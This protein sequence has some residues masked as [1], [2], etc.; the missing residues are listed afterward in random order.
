VLLA[1]AGLL[2]IVFGLIEG[3][4]YDWGT[5]WGPVSIP[6]IIAAGI[7]LLL[8][9][10]VSQARQQGREPLL[11]FRLFAD[12]NF[13]LMSAVM[14]AMGFAM[15]GLFLPLTIYYQSVLGL[16]AVDAGL[17]IAPQPLAMMVASGLAASLIPRVGGKRLLVPGLILFAAGMAAINWVAGADSGRWS[18]LPGLVVSGVGLG[19]IWTPVF[20]LATGTLEP[21]LAGVASGV[22]STIQEL[23]GVLASAMIGALLQNRL[24]LALHARAVDAA[25][26][27]PATER[28]RFVASFSN[29]AKHGFQVGRGESGT[30]M[31]L[32]PG[33]PPGVEEQ[34]ASA[35]HSVFTHAFVDAMRPS[36]ALP[37]AVIGLAALASLAAR[38]V[39][40]AAATQQR[41]EVPA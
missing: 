25:A 18:F 16:S 26:A 3:Q 12:R 41:E 34:L 39:R 17:T 4:R 20:S 14:A 7:V 21:R 15:L 40:A 5:V 28:A 2:G 6:E 23:G 38:R 10:G 30:P 33:T 29:A 36:I 37:I 24:A 1:S 8:L 13:T 27:L 9:F 31:Y 32:P 11:P 22:I 19:F 35:A